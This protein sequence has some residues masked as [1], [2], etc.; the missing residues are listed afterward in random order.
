MKSTFKPL[1]ASSCPHI[2]A[3]QLA[4]FY[5]RATLARYGLNEAEQI[6]KLYVFRVQ[7]VLPYEGFVILG[8]IWT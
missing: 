1:S 8:L 5:M 2:E 7:K 4:S 6:I 3:C